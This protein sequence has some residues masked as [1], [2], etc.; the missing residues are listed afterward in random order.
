MPIIALTIYVATLLGVTAATMTNLKAQ[1]LMLFSYA[2]DG[3]F[4]KIF[5]EIDPVKKVPLKGAWI[6]LI[7]IALAGFYL[8]LK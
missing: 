3:L 4:F 7:P 6:A 8:N 5:K 2:K 1:S